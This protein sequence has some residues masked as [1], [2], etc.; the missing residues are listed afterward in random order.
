M[1]VETI[2]LNDTITVT[3]NYTASKLSMMTR[4]KLDG[5]PAGL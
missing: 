4:A 5:K 3:V 2:F 1:T